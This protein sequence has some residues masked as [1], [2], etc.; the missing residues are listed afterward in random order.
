MSKD[1][2]TDPNS[3]YPNLFATPLFRKELSLDN[4]DLK[5]FCLYRKSIDTMGR[6]RSNVGGWQSHD[7]NFKKPP[8][9]FKEL[10][11]SIIDFSSEICDYLDL[12]FEAN[13]LVGQAWININEPGHFN[14]P[15]IHPGSIFS[16]VYYIQ[17]PDN[18]GPIEFENPAVKSMSYVMSDIAQ[19]DTN[20]YTSF[21]YKVP[22]RAS[23]LYIFP[24]WL[25]HRVHPNLSN[26]ERISISF[27]IK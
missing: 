20:I 27:N 26:E 18:C 24:S 11:K 15:H 12:S 9:E 10:F 22:T 7:Y 2:G 23:I 21:S 13:K 3:C 4:E 16:G 25:T 19:K 6:S 8:K 14:W 17:T 1:R 5:K